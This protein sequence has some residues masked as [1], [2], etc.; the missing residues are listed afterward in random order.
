MNKVIIMDLGEEKE[1]TNIISGEKLIIP[2]YGVWID[3]DVIEVG[4]NIDSLR[5]KYQN[6][7]VCEIKGSGL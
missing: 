3:N 6:Y 1:I 5:D 4:N 2:R 7:E